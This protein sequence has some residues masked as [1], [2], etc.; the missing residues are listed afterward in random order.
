MSLLKKTLYSNNFL[1]QFQFFF[2]IGNPPL[3]PD[4]KD[5][6]ICHVLCLSGD[7]GNACMCDFIPQNSRPP[8]NPNQLEKK[9]HWRNSGLP[10]W[11]YNSKQLQG[12][13]IKRR[14]SSTD[15]PICDTLCKIGEGGNAC[16][17]DWAP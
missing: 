14:D 8:A 16:M 15:P 12:K 13:D 1:K 2:V 5:S 9:R 4:E 6:N 7:G 17:C 10:Q 3:K 11:M